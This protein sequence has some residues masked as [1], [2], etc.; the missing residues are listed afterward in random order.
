MDR[1]KGY[2]HGGPGRIKGFGHGGPGRIK[3]YGYETADVNILREEKYLMVTPSTPQT[4]VWMVPGN[5][6]VYGVESNT[7]WNIE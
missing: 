1:I 2:G 4:L 5:E 7:V 6:I 3:G